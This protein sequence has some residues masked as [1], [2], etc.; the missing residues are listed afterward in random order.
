MAHNVVMHDL[1]LTR[2]RFLAGATGALGVAALGLAGC[3]PDHPTMGSVT[4]S[5]P[6][7]FLERP[8]R[9]GV[10]RWQGA[11]NLV[12]ENLKFTNRP[13][14]GNDRNDHVCIHLTDC[15]NIIIR[16]VDFDSV[17]QPLVVG[18]NCEDITV[19]RCRV[20]NITG[21]SNRVGVHSGNFLQTVDSPSN[22]SV[23]DN[24]IIGGD[25]EDI[26]SFFTAVGGLCARNRIDG[27]G[28]VSVSGTGII[29][30]DGG[31]SGIVVEDNTLLNPGQVG[32]GIAG[33]QDH[34]VRNNVIY[35]AS[36]AERTDW[37]NADGDLVAPSAEGA[38]ERAI[39]SNVGVYSLNFYPELPFGGSTV[40]NNRV[41]FWSDEEAFWNGFWDGADPAAVSEFDNI[42]SDASIDPADLAVDL[43]AWLK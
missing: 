9:D 28:W 14:T 2:R 25:T 3:G 37:F 40:H 16:N 34:V 12:I 30:G 5:G 17:A 6:V 24:L 29:V 21:P 41:R 27:S 26:I 31:G 4:S 22:T 10:I 11:E 36:Q 20:R 42:W 38:V 8:E 33:G 35:Q 23:V 1:P 19:E 18:Q 32:I 43:D 39:Q 13:Y 15:K 7:P